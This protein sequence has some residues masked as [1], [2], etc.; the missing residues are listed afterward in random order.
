ML[1]YKWRS[2]PVRD[3][4]RSAKTTARC[5]WRPK[6]SLR[7]PEEIRQQYFATNTTVERHQL[8]CPVFASTEGDILIT[9]VVDNHQRVVASAID[10]SK[11]LKIP[12]TS[13]ISF[14]WRTPNGQFT[15]KDR[16]GCTA[17]RYLLIPRIDAEC[18]MQKA[19][20]PFDHFWCGVR[21]GLFYLLD[22]RAVPLC[23]LWFSGLFTIAVFYYATLY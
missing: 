23:P 7:S 6:R 17:L 15:M 1:G 13:R 8:Q 16:P 12:S 10:S 22:F 4:R 19:W 20:L 9:A 3:H 21:N 5:V 18:G 14:T 2:L 11:I